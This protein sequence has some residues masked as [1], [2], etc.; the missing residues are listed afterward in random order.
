MYTKSDLKMF[1]FLIV[2]TILDIVV[3]KGVYN[4]MIKGPVRTTSLVIVGFNVI[5]F[6]GLLAISINQNDKDKK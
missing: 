1:L 4:Y 3:F 2:M 5:L 6:V